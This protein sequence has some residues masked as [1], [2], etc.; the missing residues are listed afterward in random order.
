VSLVIVDPD[1]DAIGD[2][3]DCVAELGFEEEEDAVETGGAGEGC[4]GRYSV[5]S[6]D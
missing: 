5:D 4:M 3:G 1:F 6:Y 2:G